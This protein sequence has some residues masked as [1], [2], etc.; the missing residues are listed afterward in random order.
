VFKEEY[1]GDLTS[2]R[3]EEGGEAGGKPSQEEEAFAAQINLID[4]VTD[5][6]SHSQLLLYFATI[7]SS[8]FISFY[9]FLR[10][11]F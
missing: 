10:S 6:V 3:G 11:I 1:F 4:A 7:P 9:S 2:K 8:N 5:K